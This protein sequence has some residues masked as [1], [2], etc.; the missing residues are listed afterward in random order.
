MTNFIFV[1]TVVLQAGKTP[2]PTRMC[3]S[4]CVYLGVYQEKGTP[5]LCAL[6][7]CLTYVVQCTV[8]FTLVKRGEVNGGHISR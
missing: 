7:P 3:V 2:C 6:M 1:C 8:V 5:D 4:V